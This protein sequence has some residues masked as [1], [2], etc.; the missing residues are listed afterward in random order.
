[1]DKTVTFKFTDALISSMGFSILSGAGLV[2]GSTITKHQVA[3]LYPQA[4]KKSPNTLYLQLPENSDYAEVLEAT[5]KNPVIG[6]RVIKLDN[7]GNPTSETI[8]VN[9][10]GESADSALTLNKDDKKKAYVLM[11]STT[12]Q[13]DANT[14]YLVDYYI[15]VA[16]SEM[17]V[18]AGKF[19]TNFLIEAT[20]LFR[21]KSDGKDLEAQFTI[22]NGK[23]QSAFT[24]TMAATGDP[25]E[26]LM[27]MAA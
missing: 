27:R 21:R 23:V 13:L 15:N 12:A 17:T 6:I 3:R 16:G 1:M 4:I 11:D 14:Q 19:A 22:P 18:E 8:K 26:N 10:Q 2:D 9:G 25:S 7:D 20:T 5:S 24:F